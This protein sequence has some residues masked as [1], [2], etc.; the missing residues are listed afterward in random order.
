[1]GTIALLFV[2]LSGAM[3]LVE[4]VRVIMVV[5]AMAVGGTMNVLLAV[6]LILRAMMVAGVAIMVVGVVG[7]MIVRDQVARVMMVVV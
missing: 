3:V 1:M 2:S 7:M 5:V 6:K 4:V